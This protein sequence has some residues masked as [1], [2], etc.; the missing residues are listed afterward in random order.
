VSLRVRNLED[1]TR[2]YCAVFGMRRGSRDGEQSRRGR[3]TVAG[4]NGGTALAVEMTEGGPILSGAGMD[5]F[6]LEVADAK[7]VSAVYAR[8]HAAG[9]RTKA[10]KRVDDRW[11]LYVFD[12]DGHKIQVFARTS[13]VPGLASATVERVASVVQGARA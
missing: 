5:H 2:F 11:E 3:C 12:P 1:S 6:S 8:A 7:D 10:P 13:E 9:A 4:P